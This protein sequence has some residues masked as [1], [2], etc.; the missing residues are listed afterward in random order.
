MA[1]QMYR[2]IV[3]DPPDPAFDTVAAPIF[4]TFPDLGSSEAAGRRRRVRRPGGAMAGRHSTPSSATRVRSPPTTSPPCAGRLGRPLT[5]PGSSSRRCARRRMPCAPTPAVLAADPEPRRACS[6]TRPSK[7]DLTTVYQPRGGVRIQ[8][9][10]ARPAD[11][12]RLHPGRRSRPSA[13]TS[14]CRSSALPDRQDARRGVVRRRG[15]AGRPT[16]HGVDLFAREAAAVA[17][18]DQPPLASFTTE[19]LGGRSVRL[20]LDVVEPGR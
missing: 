9:R 5:T 4:G 7:A 15:R 8:R 18:N 19:S 10:R 11:E 13:S 6:S 17:E 16:S 14:R 12:P 2:D 3:A 20:H 1:S